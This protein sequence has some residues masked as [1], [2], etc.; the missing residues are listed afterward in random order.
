M[1]VDPTD[2]PEVRWVRLDRH[3][4]ERGSFVETYRH[5]TWSAAGIDAG[6]VQDGWSQ[7]ARPGTVRGL[8]FQRGTDKLVRV[9]RGR[10]FEVV[11]D[12]R[13]GSAAFGAHVA[14]EVDAADW[15]QLLVPAGF[16]H[17]YCT[18][19]DD[20]VVLYKYSVPYSP[21]LEGGVLWNDPDIGIEW[22][23]DP[24]D[25]IM[26]NRDRAFPPLADLAGGI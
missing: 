22:P 7:S 8:H 15:S 16:A 5:D 3:E 26:S 11:V 18:L 19:E 12:V 20:C 23:V 6:F 14:F 13:R 21:D 25:V 2:L 9:D 4:D 1:R 24:A 17:G 10:V